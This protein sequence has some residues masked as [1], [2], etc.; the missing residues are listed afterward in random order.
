MRATL[1][2]NKYANITFRFVDIDRIDFLLRQI[3]V[4]RRTRNRV[5]RCMLQ[6]QS[7]RDAN[8]QQFIQRNN[9]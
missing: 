1:L 2:D 3:L 5:F 9:E 8:I 6:Q 7:E 4:A